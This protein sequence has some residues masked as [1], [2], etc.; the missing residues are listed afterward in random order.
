LDIYGFENIKKFAENINFKLCEEKQDKLETGLKTFTYTQPDTDRDW[1]F[2]RTVKHIGK[3]KVYDLFVP[4][5]HNFIANG[6]VTHNCNLA[7]ICLPTYY[8]TVTKQFDYNK[9]HDMVKVAT[10]NLNKAIDVNFY[11]LEKTRVSNLRHR[12]LGMGIQGLADLFALMRIPFDSEEAAVVNKNIFETMYH[13]A[14]ECSNDIAKKR[15]LDQEYLMNNRNEFDPP[16]DSKYPGAYSSFDGSPASKG[17]LQFDLWNASVTDDNWNWTKLKED[18]KLYGIRNSLLLAPMPTASTSQICG[19]NETMEPFTSN[20]YKR[21]TMAGEFILVNKY[22]LKELLDLKLWS[23]EMK[24]AIILNDGSIQKIPNIPQDIKDIYKTVWEIKQKVII[25]LA[26]DRGIFVCQSQSMNLFV[27][28]PDF[29]RLSSMHFYAWSKGLKTGLYYL[30]SKP[31]A[32]TQQFTI[33]P[34]KAGVTTNTLAVDEEP[35]VCE[36][37]S[38]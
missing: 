3:E 14:L 23:Q 33:E 5:T 38:A 30:R 24:N 25:D 1:V 7:S 27:D 19:F 6:L 8:D 29:K 10:K 9:L 36:T 18:I 13:A 15:H 22:L 28:A 12:P 32:K 2:V 20:I 34:T 31:R 11:P 21:K 37:C 4:E 26:A 35:A 16:T 17:L